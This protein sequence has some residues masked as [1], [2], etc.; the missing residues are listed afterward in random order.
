MKSSGTVTFAP[1]TP[2]PGAGPPASI[3]V[4][5]R[6]EGTSEVNL[7]RGL[8]LRHEQRVT[9]ETSR[10]VQGRSAAPGRASSTVTLTVERIR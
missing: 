4:Q 1:G 6:G 2:I 10:Q 8:L 7:D 5:V 3:T 9:T